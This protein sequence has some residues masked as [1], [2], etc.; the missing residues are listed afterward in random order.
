VIVAWTVFILFFI[1][2][3]LFVMTG[4]MDLRGKLQGKPS[5]AVWV[6]AIVWIIVTSVAAQFIWG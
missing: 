2:S 1:L 5:A 3:A 6:L 4:V